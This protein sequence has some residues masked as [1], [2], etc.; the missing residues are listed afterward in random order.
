MPEAERWT[1]LAR[2]LAEA[3]RDF[4]EQPG[5]VPEDEPLQSQEPPNAADEHAL[6]KRQRQIVE[7][8]GL[9]TE[10]GLKTAD[11]AAQIDYEVPNVYTAMQALARSQ[12]VE[13]VPSKEPQ[14]WRLVR[15]YRGGSQDYAR[16]AALL[17]PGEWATPGDISIAA[18]G[19]LRA[20]EGIARAGL[21]NT[22]SAGRRV[23]WDELAQ[24]LAASERKRT[25][26]TT[27]G[28]LNYL[29]IPAVDLEQSI[30]FYERVFGWKVTRHPAVGGT[31]EQTGY[32]EFSDASG[33]VG[34][35]F[36]LGRP[37][38]REPGLLPCIAVSSISEVL[39]SV[40]DN[41]GEVVKPRT[42]I[43]ESVDYEA[44]FRDPAG[45][46]LGLYESS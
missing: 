44:I 21:S 12:V 38:S 20:A 16:V 1:R 13:Q 39:Q 37:A 5:R 31:L 36:V 24:R 18:R 11:I 46:A 40:V 33:R 23:T 9:A 30:V 6:G 35:G 41:G 34:G 4:A 10:E 45:N 7:L 29:Q 25:M 22:G 28:V 32:P 15:R 8:P 26:P 2:V 17:R 43:V 14:H 27:N 3:L 42:A 19:D